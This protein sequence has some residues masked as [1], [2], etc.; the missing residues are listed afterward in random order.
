ML[1]LIGRKSHGDNVVIKLDMS[2][3]YDRVSWIFLTKIMRKYGFSELWIDRIW[4]LVSNNWFSIVINGHM[5]GFFKSFKGL[6]Q[7]DPLSSGLFTIVAEDLNQGL[8]KLM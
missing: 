2:K 6:K 8:H 5:A 7:G 4:R 1:S 3:A